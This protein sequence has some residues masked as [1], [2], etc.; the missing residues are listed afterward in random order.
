[1]R[2]FLQQVGLRV[3]GAGAGLRKPQQREDLRI[4]GPGGLIGQTQ[5]DFLSAIEGAGVASDIEKLSSTSTMWCV[6]A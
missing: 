3:A 6:L 2:G 1:M 4:V 5:D